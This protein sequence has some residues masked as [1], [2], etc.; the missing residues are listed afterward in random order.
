MDENNVEFGFSSPLWMAKAV[1]CTADAHLLRAAVC[2][3][4]SYLWGADEEGI[5]PSEVFER[6]V[7]ISTRGE[8]VPVEISREDYEAA[9]KVADEIIERNID[10][11]VEEFRKELDE[12][13]GGD[14]D[15]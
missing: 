2:D 9:V 5:D 8:Y 10:G 7:Q 11:E 12:T 15:D 6:I 13:L 4:L 1:V 3:V 14:D